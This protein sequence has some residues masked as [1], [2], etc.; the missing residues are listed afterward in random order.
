MNISCWLQQNAKLRK[1]TCDRYLFMFTYLRAPC[2]QRHTHCPLDRCLSRSLSLPRHSFSPV[3]ALS[4]SLSLSLWRRCE[5]ETGSD[6]H[7]LLSGGWSRLPS[8]SPTSL[9]SLSAYRYPSNG[10]SDLCEVSASRSDR[11]LEEEMVVWHR[12]RKV[13]RLLMK[14]MSEECEGT[15]T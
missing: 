13:L 8:P 3:F 10:Q 6:R 2:H 9:T 4:H 12:M 1:S 5:T 7:F 15:H 11:F 14:M